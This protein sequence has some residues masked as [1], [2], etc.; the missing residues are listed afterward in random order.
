MNRV[1]T[2][3]VCAYPVLQTNMTLPSQL[4]RT[5]KG[6]VGPVHCVRFDSKN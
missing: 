4:K 5:L 2:L 6:H 3:Q 1:Q